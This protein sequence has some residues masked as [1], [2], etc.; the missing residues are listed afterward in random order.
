[1]DACCDAYCCLLAPSSIFFMQD[2]IAATFKD[3]TDINDTLSDIRNGRKSFDDFPM[4]NVVQ[5]IDKKDIPEEEWDRKFTTQTHGQ[6]VKIRHRGR[7]VD[8]SESGF[9]SDEC[10]SD[11]SDGYECPVDYCDRVCDTARALQQHQESKGHFVYDSESDTEGYESPVDYCDRVCNTATA[12]RQHQ[13][14]K[15]HF[16]KDSESDTEGYE[17]PVDYCDRV[18]NTAT[19]LR[20]HQ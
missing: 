10:S 9:N 20:Q 1:M 18:C 7:N 14:S 6:S 2:S 3:K 16:V 13:E 15:S 11:E 12:L 8:N 17:S 4:M 19:A 5:L